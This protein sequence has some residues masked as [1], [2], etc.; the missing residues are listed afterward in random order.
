MVGPF[1][2][3]ARYPLRGLGWLP[4]RSLRIFVLV[5]LLINVLLFVFAGWW[6]A[7]RVDALSRRLLGNLNT[8]LPT[9][10]GWLSDLLYWLIWPLFLLAILLVVF[11]T[12]T[13]VA[14][15][16]GSPFNG[17]LAERVEVIATGR[18][19][20][21]P[22]SLWQEVLQAPMV[23]LRKLA[24]FLLR[25]VPLLV[26]FVIP[27]VNILAPLIWGL[28]GA[29][30]LA[31]QY[32]EYPLSNHGIAIDEQRQRL[33]ERRSLALGF[34]AA[35]LLMTLMP[36]LNF[37]VMPAAVIGATLLVVEEFPGVSDPSTPE[38]PD[39]R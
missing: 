4:R 3:G 13:L 11:Y 29:W 9:W 27:L 34:G 32:V 30:M 7:S 10:L 17:L 37:L 1:L 19:P 25:A 2:R 18:A 5:P 16:I 33:A 14:N 21:S 28:F 35:T 23:E 38:T 6:S 8:W 26:L 39:E 22:L 12:F 31:L 20:V 36:G 24:Y 15:F